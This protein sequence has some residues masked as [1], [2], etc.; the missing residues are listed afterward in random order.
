LLGSKH[1]TAAVSHSGLTDLVRLSDDEVHSLEESLLPSEE[2]ESIISSW[3][4]DLPQQTQQMQEQEQQ[5][6][7]G[8]ATGCA[9]S[10]R[11]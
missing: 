5:P 10:G 11:R 3:V 8:A 2:D 4:A 6:A 7:I 9:S 1:F